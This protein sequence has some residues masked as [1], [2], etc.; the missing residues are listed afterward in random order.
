MCHP[1]ETYMLTLAVIL[2]CRYCEVL[3]PVNFLASILYFSV[4]KYGL[5]Y[6]TIV[7]MNS[8]CTVY[9]LL[10]LPTVE[11]FIAMMINIK[12]TTSLALRCCDL[13]LL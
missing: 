7:D 12:F 10:H 6:I 8:L 9:K 5:L 3:L 2:S 11:N 1:Y 13:R 4:K